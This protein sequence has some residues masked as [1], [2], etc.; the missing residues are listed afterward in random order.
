[1]STPKELFTRALAST[2]TTP[3]RL[4]TSLALLIAG[5]AGLTLA[6]SAGTATFI[7]AF[8]Q[9]GEEAVPAYI[10]TQELRA[11][12]SEVQASAANELVG[13]PGENTVS[14]KNYNVKLQQSTKLVLALSN[15]AGES[16]S[17]LVDKLSA[18]ITQY[19]SLI[20]QARQL[21]VRGDAAYLAAYRRAGTVMSE[22]LIPNAEKLGK[23]QSDHSLQAYSSAGAAAGGVVVAFLLSGGLLIGVLVNTQLFMRD[24]MRRI[25]NPYLLAA[26][27]ISGLVFAVGCLTLTKSAFRLGQSE[28]SLVAPISQGW[29]QRASAYELKG[30]QSVR[31]LDKPQQ[32]VY[33]GAFAS[34]AAALGTKPFSRELAAFLAVDSRIVQLESQGNHAR[35][36][37]TLIGHSQGESNFAFKKYDEAMG[38]VT[39]GLTMK[40]SQMVDQELGTL[41]FFSRAGQFLIPLAGVLSFLGIRKRL[42]EYSI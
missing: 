28:T 35:A 38:A 18:G 42:D 24:R 21:H 11:T 14:L 36:L 23:L 30:L 4:K 7:Q 34:R 10:K 19:N 9:T 25:V 5:A 29:A 8:R 16:E 17:E 15:S 3:G 1:M 27:G 12:L 41:V 32:S 22:S 39:D 33:A 20:T 13:R 2:A 37:A 6:T 40:L 26:T 31:V